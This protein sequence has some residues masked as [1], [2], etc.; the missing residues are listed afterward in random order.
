LLGYGLGWECGSKGNEARVENIYLNIS[1]LNL[2]MLI[3]EKFG[4]FQILGYCLDKDKDMILSFNL[5]S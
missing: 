4:N 2:N 5:R 1:H 3:F